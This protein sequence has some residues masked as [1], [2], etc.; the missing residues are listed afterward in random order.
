M[1]LG[2]HRDKGHRVATLGDGITEAGVARFRLGLVRIHH[3]VSHQE[4]SNY[5]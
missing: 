1:C 3:L 4:D 2:S 5:D